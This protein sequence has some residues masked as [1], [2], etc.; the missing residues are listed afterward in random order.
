MKVEPGPDSEIQPME[1]DDPH[2]VPAS[3]SEDIPP[4]CDD[5]DVDADDD[6][7][8]D[9]SDSDS[10]YSDD[11]LSDEEFVWPLP[12]CVF[13]TKLSKSQLE[14]SSLVSYLNFYLI[15]IHC[16]L[17]VKIIYHIFY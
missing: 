13:V 10:D 14:G 16:I 8:D 6:D 1:V 9:D 3:A 2:L 17:C 11:G 15:G 4:Q 5:D 7:S 12:R